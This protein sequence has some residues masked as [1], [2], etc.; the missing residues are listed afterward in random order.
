MKRLTVPS[1]RSSMDLASSQ[2]A[3]PAGGRYALYDVLAMVRR[4]GLAGT[5]SLDH[6]FG[7]LD[8]SSTADLPRK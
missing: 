3:W 8:A 4:L 5:F 7:R 1:R 6:G 2:S